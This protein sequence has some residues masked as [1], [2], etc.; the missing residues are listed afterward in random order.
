MISSKTATLLTGMMVSVVERGE[1]TKGKVPGYYV[2]G[3]TGTAQIPDYEH[4]GYS[5][6]LNHSFIGFA[7][8][9]DPA[10]LMIIKFENPKKG[11]FASI[12]TAPL[13]SRMAKF[14]LDYYHIVPD[15]L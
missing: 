3:K 4:G 5:N 2:A 6:K 9:K 13:F 14:I 11:S 10:F 8:I 1:G 12:T 15:A 7:P